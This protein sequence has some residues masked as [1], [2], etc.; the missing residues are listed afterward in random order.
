[1]YRNQIQAM[2]DHSEINIVEI[3]EKYCMKKSKN[4]GV[5]RKEK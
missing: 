4:M 5:E 1:M 3:I 2:I